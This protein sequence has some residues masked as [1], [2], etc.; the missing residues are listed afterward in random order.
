M[1]KM[2]IDEFLRRELG[3]KGKILNLVHH[4]TYEEIKR[5]IL[6]Y[7]DQEPNPNSELQERSDKNADQKP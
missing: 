6:K 3:V 4:L 2:D 1:P 7:L 5:L